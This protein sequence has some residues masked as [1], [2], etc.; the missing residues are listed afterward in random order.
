M[1]IARSI[2]E[3]SLDLT[4]GCCV[5][6]GNFDGVHNGH[7]KLINRTKA[8]AAAMGVPSVVVTFCPHPLQVLAGSHAPALITDYEKKL[9]LLEAIG[10]DLV[11]M[12][13]F[14]RDFAAL[15]PEEFV[16]TILCDKLNMKELVVGYDYAFGKGRKGNFELL[17]MLGEKYGYSI[18]RLE[19]VII[20]DAIVSSTRIRDLIKAGNVWDVYPLMDRFYV[21]RGTVIHG[22][23]RGGK[24]LGFPTANMRVRDDLHPKPGVYATWA[25]LDG[26]AYKA[27]T[28]IGYNPT[29]GNDEI[30]VE[31]FILDFDQ[32]IYGWELRLNFVARMRDEKKFSGLDE[33]IAQITSDVSLARQ[34]LSE[35]EA[36]L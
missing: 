29:F 13:E 34:L 11:L 35:N 16:K 1:Q 23:D 7:R 24:L 36:Q 21:I 8:K 27:V 30:S 25:E 22:M 9:D 26:T 15:D 17:S 33:L 31:T 12:L 32:D 19:P 2:Q 5:T 14:T 10:V 20:N 3:I 4:K 6:I 28:N 18:E